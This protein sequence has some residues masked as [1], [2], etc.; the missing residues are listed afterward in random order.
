MFIACVDMQ[1]PDCT[2]KEFKKSWK[3]RLTLWRVPSV[4]SSVNTAKTTSWIPSRG[5][6]VRVDLASLE[7]QTQNRSCSFCD[8][9]LPLDLV[10]VQCFAQRHFSRDA[11]FCLFNTCFPVKGQSPCTNPAAQNVSDIAIL[12][13]ITCN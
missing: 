5:I 1:C 8:G 9:L 11:L 7:S 6:R 2:W 10:S 4:C 12:F 13:E 3:K